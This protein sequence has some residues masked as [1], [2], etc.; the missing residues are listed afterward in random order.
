MHGHPPAH[1]LCDGCPS[2]LTL[3]SGEDGYVEDRRRRPLGR[4]GSH[5]G[6][7]VT[8]QQGRERWHVRR[9]KVARSHPD[10][11]RLRASA[12]AARTRNTNRRSGVVVLVWVMSCRGHRMPGREGLRARRVRCL[13]NA[14]GRS[15]PGAGRQRHCQERSNRQG[16]DEGSQS[17]IHRTSCS[18]SRNPSRRRGRLSR[19]GMT[20][21]LATCSQDHLRRFWRSWPCRSR[22]PASPVGVLLAPQPHRI[23]VQLHRSSASTA[24]T[25]S[26]TSTG[27]LFQP[28]TIATLI[29]WP[30]SSTRSCSSSSACSAGVRGRLTKSS[31]KSRR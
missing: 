11:G 16:C 24:A 25:S 21:R 7:R 6:L 27:T 22:V 14:T 31:R 15:R 26:G 20:T 1:D 13:G 5:F 29:R 10:L 28:S 30:D 18:R 3:Q 19:T 23:C 2:G 12:A 17:S 9:C 4:S 8:Q